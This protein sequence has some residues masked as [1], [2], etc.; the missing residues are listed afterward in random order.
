MLKE[1]LWIINIEL[2][3]IIIIKKYK[4]WKFSFNWEKIN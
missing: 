4:Y 1:K 3:S 2:F